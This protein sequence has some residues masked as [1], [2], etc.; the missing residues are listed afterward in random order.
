MEFSTSPNQIIKTVAD[1][2]HT[3]SKVIELYEISEIIK[4]FG[5]WVVTKY[6]LE[7]LVLSY[8]ISKDRLTETDWVI[9]MSDKRWV[10]ID[11]FEAAL[12]FA[13]EYHY[14]EP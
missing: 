8:P 2:S 14:N 6:G 1:G 11:E 13:V 12:K 5:Q 3:L 9:H 10:V 4:R 7:S